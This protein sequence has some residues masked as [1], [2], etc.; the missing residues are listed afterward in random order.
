MLAPATTRDEHARQVE[1]AALFDLE[2]KLRAIVKH[3][4]TEG[5]GT[6]LTIGLQRH[7]LGV[8]VGTLATANRIRETPRAAAERRVT[9]RWPR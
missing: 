1:N 9:V 4:H 7:V 2:R 5:W 6:G 8:A 3:R